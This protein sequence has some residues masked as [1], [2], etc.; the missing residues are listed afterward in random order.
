MPKSGT[1]GGAKF[2]YSDLLEGESVYAP[3]EGVISQTVQTGYA[4]KPYAVTVESAGLM[5]CK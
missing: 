1:V 4:S 2:Q 3:L 5:W